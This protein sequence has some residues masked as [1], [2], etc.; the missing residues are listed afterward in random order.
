MGTLAEQLESFV[1]GL[2][3]STAGFGLFVAAFFDSSLL[4]LP[5]INDVLLIY[6]G[7]EFPERAYFYASM[8]VLGSASGASLLY[9]LARWKGHALLKRKFEAGKIDRVFRLFKRYGALAVAVPAILPPPFPFKI[10]VLS[11]GVLGLPY[12]YFLVAILMGRSFRYFGEAFLAVRFGEVTVTYLRENATAVL[13]GTLLVMAVAVGIYV[14]VSR[15]R[16]GAGDE[17]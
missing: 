6:F 12:R 13:V 7:T 5:E 11:S 17:V 8:T 14:L 3:S 1:R 10:F 15:S 2:D 4:S 16:A 9:W